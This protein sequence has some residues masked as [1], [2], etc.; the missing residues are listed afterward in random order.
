MDIQTQ[1]NKILAQ[2]KSEKSEKLKKAM[3]TIADIIQTAIDNNFESK[4]RTNGSSDLFDGG[5]QSWKPLSKSYIKYLQKKKIT[6]LVATLQRSGILRQS[7]RVNPKGTS[8]SISVDSRVPY[9]YRMQE[10][11]PFIQ[12]TSEDVDE[13]RDYLL[14]FL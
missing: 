1:I 11:R 14:N 12:L 3:L 5:S 9:A 10:E 7:I 4:G 6:P 13:I 8:V 2:I